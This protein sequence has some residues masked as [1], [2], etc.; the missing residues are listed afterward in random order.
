MEDLLYRI[1]GLI[2]KA[3]NRIL[4][5]N[6]AYEYN[7]TD[8]ELHFL[9]IGIVGMAGIFLFYPLFKALADHGHVMVVTWIYVFTLILGLTFAIEIGQRVSHTGI[10]DFGD[11][12]FGVCGFFAMFAVFAVFRA[13]IQAIAG[14]ARKNRRRRSRK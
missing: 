7:F 2:A 5:L 3:H 6:D 13:I 9:V 4:A 1:V 12:V 10:M 11:I 8:K 14:A